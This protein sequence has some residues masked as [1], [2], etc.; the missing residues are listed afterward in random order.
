M[1]EE[2][3]DILGHPMVITVMGG[4]GVLV[5]RWMKK[6]EKKIDINTDDIQEVE[7]DTAVLNDAR[8]RNDIAVMALQKDILE[9][10]NEMNGAISKLT[11]NVNTLAEGMGLNRL[12]IDNM[13]SELG[14]ISKRVRS[15]NE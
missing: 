9:T 2:I 8:A 5:G 3:M 1:T 7:K 15:R 4:I 6:T 10:Q 11:I 12:D 13:K 14:F